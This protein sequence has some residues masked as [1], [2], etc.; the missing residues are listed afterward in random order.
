MNLKRLLNHIFG[1][2]TYWFT[3]YDTFQFHP[4]LSTKTINNNVQLSHT[5]IHI[6]TVNVCAICFN[7]RTNWKG[8]SC[9]NILLRSPVRRTFRNTL[10]YL[11]TVG[12]LSNFLERLL[13]LLVQCFFLIKQLRVAPPFFV[14]MFKISSRIILPCY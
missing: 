13:N 11:F 10:R 3:Y 1:L 12:S 2:F 4:V 5:I 9:C 8:L 14:R 6:I 7:F